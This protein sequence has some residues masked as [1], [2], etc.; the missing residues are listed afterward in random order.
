MIKSPKRNQV[1]DLMII[2]KPQASAWGIPT[3]RSV[4]SDQVG[5]LMIMPKPQASAWGISCK[6]SVASERRFMVSFFALLIALC[7]IG[8]SRP[9]VP[10]DG[11]TEMSGIPTIYPDYTGLVIPPNI[12]PL[13]FEI[14]IPGQ[15]YVA[16]AYSPSGKEIL[17]EGKTVKWDLKDWHS[18][19]EESKGK[20]IKFEIF[21]KDDSGKWNKYCFS[22]KVAAEEI[23]PY[24]SYRLIEPLY[25]LYGSLS[26]CQRNL[27]S[28]DEDI[29]FNNS[30]H[31][32]PGRQFCIN[33]HIPRNQYRDEA[34]QIHVRHFNGGTLI[35]AGDSIQKVNMKCDSTITSGVYTAWHPTHDL[36][37]Y[38]TNETR[39]KFFSFSDTRPE[40]FDLRSDI[41]LYDMKNQTIKNV[42]N[43]PDLLETY[44]SW[45]PDGKSIF[46]AAARYPEGVTAETEKDHLK[47]IRYD[48]IRRR[49][50]P[51]SQVFSQPDTVV[52]ASAQ[53]QSA[54]H[55]RISPDGK[56]LLYCK[57]PFGTFHLPHSES[58]LFMLN[59]ATG[60][61]HPLSSANSKDSESYHSWSSN[62]RWVVFSSRREDGQYTHPYIA[63]IDKDGVDSKAFIMPQEDPQHYAQLMK[64]Y[65]VPEFFVKPFK[66]S[67]A[68][69]TK[70]LEGDATPAAFITQ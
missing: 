44:P 7:L 21:V 33:C 27:E 50:D 30:T 66:F 20:D 37:A 10:T 14:D 56:W 2:Q 43:D 19:L 15:E 28:W 8:C 23:D 32:T 60:E 42:A 69:I 29:V 45:H 26:I 13:N 34:S 38:S 52:Y 12:A 49:F 36:I 59:L 53:E 3:H 46:Y 64:S 48:I 63:Y 62:S 55:P 41:I 57:A 47:E 6:S 68:R 70:A 65:N 5:D 24:I 22:N 17:A 16:R 54:L 40:V 61:E 58:D 51:E 11:V 18:L 1:G 4:A 35:M 9:K 39:Q 67:R 25:T 31:T